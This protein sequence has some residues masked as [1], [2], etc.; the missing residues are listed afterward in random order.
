MSTVYSDNYSRFAVYG[1]K[2][3]PGFQ[4]TENIGILETYECAAL[5]SGSTI[6]MF[7]PPAGAKYIGGKM[8]WDDMGSAAVTFAVGT[9]VTGAG[10]AANT[11][12]FL[13]ATDVQ[14]AADET[15]LD[16]GAAEI[17]VLGYEFDGET[18]VI[19]TTAGGNAATGTVKLLMELLWAF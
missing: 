14:S 17:D 9:G 16:A 18:P 13:G 1:K 12:K 2:G 10:V 19:I 6:Y 8:A 4:G 11:T 15:I 5:A 3:Y 7:I